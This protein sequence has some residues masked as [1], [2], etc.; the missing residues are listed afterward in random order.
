MSKTL[1]VVNHRMVIDQADDPTTITVGQVDLALALSKTLGRNI[2]QGHS[3]RVVGINAALDHSSADDADTGLAA[4]VKI[5]YCPTNRHGVK[6]WNDMFRRWKRQKSLAGKVGQSVRY[7]DFEPGY[8]P[9]GITSRTST[10]YA[11][12]LGDTTAESITLYGNASSGSRTSLEDSYNS[13][14]PIPQAST[15]EFG[16]S[17]KSPKFTN[18]FPQEASLM[19]TAHMSAKAAWTRS[20]TFSIGAVSG[21]DADAGSTH[22]MGGSAST[23]MLAFPGG[24]NIQAMCGL[25]QVSA[26]L[27]PHDVDSGPDP[28]T[29]ETNW[30]LDL[31]FFVEGWTP[32]AS[33]P[34]KKST[35]RITKRRKTSKRRTK[36]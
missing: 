1:H 25:F 6:A 31:T 15:D 18:H 35:K 26:C 21:S 32:L 11:S 17:V 9:L 10:L 22:Y 5:Q 29:A 30:Y 4:A 34:K 33:S 27:L 7:D 13:R 36:R 19:T 8:G 2:R 3:F 20:I 14:N 16:V 12:G 24:G 23:G 28:P